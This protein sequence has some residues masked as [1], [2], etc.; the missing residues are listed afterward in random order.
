MRQARTQ[1]GPMTLQQLLD[2]MNAAKAAY[3]AKPEDTALKAAY[4]SAKTAYE[5]K[6][7]EEEGEGEP[8]ESKFDD[9]T[10]A[11]I[12]KLRGENAKHRTKAKELASKLTTTE[13]QKKAILKAAG[14]EDESENP[15]EKLKLTTSKNQELEFR[16]AILETA[17]EHGIAKDDVKYFSFLVQEASSQLKDDEELSDEALKLIVADVRKRGSG[18]SASTSVGGGG[19]G[20]DENPNPEDKGGAVKLDDFVRMN[21]S[22][23]TKLYGQNPDL[24]NQ[25]VAE[26]KR[27]NRLI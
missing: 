17:L 3:D 23:K 5:A 1:K 2:A 4:E 11:Y 20:K 21:F 16:S 7:A 10:K 26:A 27:T 14:I 15:E 22:E 6:K 12:A 24:Y 18:K 13:A 19:K 9:A 25:L 8:D